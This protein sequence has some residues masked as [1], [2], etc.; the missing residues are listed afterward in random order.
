M[1]LRLKSSMITVGLNKQRKL[2][3]EFFKTTGNKHLVNL[4]DSTNCCVTD[5]IS[6]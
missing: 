6:Q 1:E 4:E 3:H 5:A 2:R